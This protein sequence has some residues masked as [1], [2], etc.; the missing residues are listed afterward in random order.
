MGNAKA[1]QRPDKGP[2]KARL[3]P[4]KGPIQSRGRKGEEEKEEMQEVLSFCLTPKS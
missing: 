1:K 2:T 3:R 4:G